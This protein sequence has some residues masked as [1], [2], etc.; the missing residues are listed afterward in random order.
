MY[1]FEIPAKSLIFLQA[2]V[3]IGV[4]LLIWRYGLVPYGVGVSGKIPRLKTFSVHGMFPLAIVQIFAG[5]LLGPSVFGALWEDGY[6][7]L[8]RDDV[9]R[10]IDAIA[11]MGIVL[12]VFI[13][14]CEADRS[15]MRKSAGVVLRI[16]LSG[17]FLAWIAGG[18]AALYIVDSFTG[19]AVF[20][21]VGIESPTL[22]AV[23]FGLCMSVTALPILVL[24][25]RDLGFG[26][27]PIGTIAVAIA[28]IDD[29]LLWLSVAVILP[30][31]T[32][33]N[34][35][36]AF[37]AAVAGAVVVLCSI[38]YVIGPYLD[39]LLDKGAP[40]RFLVSAVVLVL[41]ASVLITDVTG[42]HAV[43]GAFIT[44]LAMPDRLRH[45]AQEKLDL[46][47]NLVL[48]PFF[49]LATGLRTNFAFDDPAIWTIFGIGLAACIF[50]KFIGVTIPAYLSGQSGP[51]SVTLGLLMQC[52]GLMEIL[53]VTILY[54]RGVFG[55]VTYSALILVALVS[56]AITAPLCRLM[57]G[58]YG[59]K[60]L[61]IRDAIEPQTEVSSRGASGD[62]G[63]PVLV[64]SD[65]LGVVPITSTDTTIGRHSEDDVRV[66]AV[67]VS[68][69]HA[70]L[71]QRDDGSYELHNQTA[72]LW[73][74]NPMTVN[75]EER[76]HAVLADGDAIELGGVGFT[77]R[78]P[79]ATGG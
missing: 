77:F 75:G 12:F 18:L 36:I 4:P 38:L 23:A 69:H 6:N 64:F 35:V 47:V 70:L 24:V 27:K 67:T 54:E 21:S 65:S 13:A 62:A 40:E 50:G 59:P 8:F 73:R 51:F 22:Y 34:L 46:P 31:A 42:I 3:I 45:M 29:I 33:G 48:M 66:D 28:G 32:G 79:A 56:T 76:E 19:T 43:V 63:V 39:R 26:G 9:R 55:T 16:G 15:I 14:G 30:F 72:G 25:L 7:Y 53:V 5:I 60:A 71:K 2:F 58:L 74:P 78:Y 11:Q 68:R 52:K 61:E 57:I 1:G 37:A 44:G 49:F 10:G 20:G 17:V 41:F